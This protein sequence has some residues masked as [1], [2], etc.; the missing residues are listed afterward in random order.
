[1]RL[2]IGMTGSVGILSFVPQVPVWRQI[3]CTEAQ[4]ILSAAAETF[5]SCTAVSAAT[6]CR[7][8]AS[9]VSQDG[10][11][12]RPLHVS[13]G[14]W[15][16]GLVIVPTTANTLASLATGR[17]DSLLTLT[18]LGLQKPRVVVP[19]MNDKMWASPPVR[20]N[21]ES[22]VA[23]GW[24]VYG[25]EEGVASEGANRRLTVPTAEELA[26]YLAKELAR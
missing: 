22:L 16:D 26:R 1:M 10:G 23:D 17:A 4:I 9:D 18:V 20:R 19:N 6:G 21:V 8:H 2:L 25:S 14:E 7:V 12:G 13:L 15:C 24:S 11:E 5:V 3:F